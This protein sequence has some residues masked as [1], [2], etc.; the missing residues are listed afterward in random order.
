[1]SLCAGLAPMARRR[2]APAAFASRCISDSAT[3]AFTEVVMPVL[4]PIDKRVSDGCEVTV[5][6]VERGGACGC[7]CLVCGDDLIV[8]QGDVNVWHF[9]HSSGGGDSCNESVMHK[10]AK[11][12]LIESRGK[13]LYVPD[14][15][16]G[17][18]WVVEDVRLEQW[19]EKAKRKPDALMRMSIRDGG[20]RGTEI[21]REVIAVEICVSNPK[22]D[23][24]IRDMRVAGTSA[25]EIDIN[26][27]M[28]QLW[29]NKRSNPHLSGRRQSS[30]ATAWHQAV[31]KCVMG[32][33]RDNRCWLNRSPH[34]WQ[35]CSVCGEALAKRGDACSSCADGKT[36]RCACGTS[37]KPQYSQCYRCYT[38][39]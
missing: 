8:K 27:E 5:F 2:V 20:K 11:R 7:I 21:V 36:A 1:M 37:I 26:A 18:R 13:A 22:D 32:P 24:Y 19:Y 33:W 4:N 3:T 16:S 38:N 23:D 31:T 12:V 6:D 9:A 25:L 28:I 14:A 34:V 17:H 39:D 10:V 15:P 29:L 30:G 35:I